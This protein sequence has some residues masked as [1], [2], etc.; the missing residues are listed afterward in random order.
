MPAITKLSEGEIKDRLDALPE[1]SESGGVIQR[2][3][4]FKDFVASMRFVNRIAELAEQRQH[5]PDILVRWN[6]VTLSLSTHDAGG[7]SERDFDFARLADG[8]R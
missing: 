3:F 4:Q 7:I 6:K 2:T 5:H 8:I 1:W